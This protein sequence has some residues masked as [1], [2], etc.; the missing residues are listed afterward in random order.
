MGSFCLLG[1]TKSDAIAIRSIY[2]YHL[3]N[4]KSYS[5]LHDLCKNIGGRLSGSPQ[6]AKAVEWAAKA[7]WDAGADTVF[8][9]PCMVPHWER[10]AKE[11]GEIRNR[12]DIKNL[13]VCA[14][15]G[16]VETGA[17]GILAQVVEVASFE[18]LDKLGEKGVRGKIVFY[19]VSFNPEWINTGA[20]YGSN[21]KYRTSGA[22]RAAKWGAVA[23]VVKSMTLSDNDFPHTGV[24]NYD[25]LVKEKIPAF[26]ISAKGARELAEEL[27][28]EKNSSLY[29]FSDCKMLKDEPSFSV[30]GEIR[31]NET[32][33]DI[34]VAGG[35]LDSWDLGEGAHDDGAGV[36]Q[37]IEILAAIKN[38]KIKNKKTIRVI[39][40][41]NEENGLRG[42]NAYLAFAEKEKKRHL[43]AIE[44]DGGGLSPRSLGISTQGDTL[45]YFKKWNPLFAPYD[46]QIIGGGG[47]ADVGPLKKMGAFEMSLIVDNQRYFD[48]HHT[49]DDVFENVHKRELELGAAAMTALIYLFDK[50]GF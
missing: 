36:V 40:F 18:E 32:P 46:I 2:N 38:C 47:G 11:I 27:H 44:S 3:S 42:A 25:T 35:H 50:Y 24:M 1:Q 6:A 12:K 10:G 8:L 34:L 31:G 14:L 19:N 4:S 48:Y 13:S 21:V 28:R 20:S 45:L 33:N 22:S 43:G 26:A 41:M 9:V 7:M 37:S 16:S 23:S 30:V 5:N 49:R 39:A 29:L 15:G 17:S